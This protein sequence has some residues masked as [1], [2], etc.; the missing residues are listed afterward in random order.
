MKLQDYRDT[1]YTFSGKA[2]DLNRQLAFAAIALIWLFKKDVAGQ[3]AIP[4]QLILPG[5]LVAASLTLDMLHYCVAS[6]IWRRF[7]TRKEKEGVSE[8]AQ[9]DHDASL[10]RPIWIFFV[11]K[12]VCVVAAYL[13]IL[14]FLI[15]RLT[16]SG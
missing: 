14:I 2:S 9:L 11:L 10:E 16:Q 5:A 4:H 3:P 1:F 15:S 8:G 13:F 6:F 7:Y 12:I